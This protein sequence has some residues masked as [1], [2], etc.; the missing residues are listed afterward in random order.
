[1]LTWHYSYLLSAWYNSFNK[2]NKLPFVK[3]N[4]SNCKKSTENNFLII[5]DEILHNLGVNRE[6]NNNIFK[7]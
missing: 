3:F 4:K 7:L 5:L 2:F 6:F 1:M